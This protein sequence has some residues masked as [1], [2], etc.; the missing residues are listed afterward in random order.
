LFCTNNAKAA[1]GSHTSARQSAAYGVVWIK[2]GA[3]AAAH[4]AA[5]GSACTQPPQK[6]K[7]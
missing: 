2:H 1:K 4:C 5:S 7:P 6:A 3:K